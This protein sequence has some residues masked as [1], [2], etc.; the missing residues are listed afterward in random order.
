MGVVLWASVFHLLRPAYRARLVFYDE[1]W[2][3]HCETLVNDRWCVYVSRAW[4]D[5]QCRCVLTVY[6]Q[7]HRLMAVGVAT[8]VDTYMYSASQF[9]NKSE[10]WPSCRIFEFWMS[11]NLFPFYLPY[12]GY[13]ILDIGRWS[14]KTL[15]FCVPFI[16]HATSANSR[17]ITG[18]E[19]S[20]SDTVLLVV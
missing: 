2:W 7:S 6:I 15:I 16:S 5:V 8:S 18:R 11:V 12:I 3:H 17:K 4:R 10:D 13:R 20:V 9:V 1:R 19:Y 14:C